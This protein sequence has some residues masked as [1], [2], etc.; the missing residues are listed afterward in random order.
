MN[1]ENIHLVTD[2]GLV[3]GGF[4]RYVI[5]APVNEILWICQ[6]RVAKLQGEVSRR[7]THTDQA[8]GKEKMSPSK[9]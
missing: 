3:G 1:I 8:K 5:V 2:L 4:T 7:D 9:L 6:R